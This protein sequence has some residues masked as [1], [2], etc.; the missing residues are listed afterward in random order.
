[1]SDILSVVQD[2]PGI[3]PGAIATILRIDKSNC[4]RD[5]LKLADR[6][7]I[8]AEYNGSG[9]AFV[10]ASDIPITA[11]T[12]G[13]YRQ[14]EFPRSTGKSYSMAAP[15]IQPDRQPPE[16]II[17]ANFREVPSFD[18]RLAQPH[19]PTSTGTA[20]TIHRM[21]ATPVSGARRDVQPYQPSAVAELSNVFN[22][23]FVAD[24]TGEIVSASLARQET[25]GRG[26]G[27]SWRKSAR[28]MR[29]GWPRPSV[30]RRINGRGRLSDRY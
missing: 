28:S 27:R 16:Q 2:H 5:A 17:D 24:P 9:Y 19:G 18:S 4:R 30:P 25:L 12:T 26:S 7:L 22:S 3:S 15:S 20:L 29:G 6:G 21:P 1:M 11:N 13:L 10:P 8:R 23:M 14:P